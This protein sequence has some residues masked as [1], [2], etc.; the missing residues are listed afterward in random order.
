[1]NNCDNCIYSS[2]NSFST[3]LKCA[4]N[5]VLLNNKCYEKCP[6]GYYKNLDVNSATNGSSYC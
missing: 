3:C 1:M 5:Y 4:S 2:G 6:I